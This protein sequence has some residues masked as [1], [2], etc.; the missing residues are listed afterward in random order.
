MAPSLVIKTVNDIAARLYTE[1]PADD[2]IEKRLA[3]QVVAAQKN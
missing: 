1:N 2:K 3:E